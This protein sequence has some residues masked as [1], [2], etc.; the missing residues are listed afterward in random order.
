MA[1]KH[2]SWRDGPA[3]LERHSLTKHE[4]LVEYLK[5]YFTQRTL[6]ARGRDR[7]RITLV[8]GFCGGGEYLLRDTGQLIEGSPLRI[9]KAVNEAQ[10]LVNLDRVKPLLLDVQYIFVDENK[11][12][13]EYLRSLLVKRGYGNQIGTS[14]HLVCSEFVATSDAVLAAIGRHTPKRR[15]RCFSSI[16]TGTQMFLHR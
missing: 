13:V 11:A 4:V 8:D 3:T 16:N 2:Y 10:A 5:R 12:A 7:F 1:K 6:N 9:L 14:I 15:P